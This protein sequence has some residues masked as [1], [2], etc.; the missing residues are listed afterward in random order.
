MDHVFEGSCPHCMH[1]LQIPAELVNFSCMY[2]GARLRQDE[3][4][5]P[6]VSSADCADAM[7][8]VKEHL[9]DA[10]T[11]FAGYEKKITKKEYASAFS[12]YERGVAKT[13]EALDRA[14]NA[15][16][17]QRSELIL[18]TVTAFID[19]TE[20]L[21]MAA[22]EKKQKQERAMFNSKMIIALF[23]VPAI[24]HLRLSVSEDYADLL[25]KQWLKRFPDNPFHPATYEDIVSGFRKGILCFITTAVCEAEGKP[26]NCAELTAFRA[27]R[28]GFLT[29][30]PDGKA[31]IDE[32]Y[33]IAPAIVNAINYCDQS[34]A[35]YTELREGFLSRCYQDLL[36]GRN[37][38]CKAEYTSMVQTLKHR[39]L[40]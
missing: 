24:R 14:C 22:S 23:L 4:I 17:A 37:E 7:D 6:E 10:L 40:Q 2:C 32:Y 31:L 19:G 16:P 35:V 36:A 26:D 27:F 13:Y 3:L 38:E 5:L 33:D 29:S 21:A 18:Q 9:M 1:E 28:D 11:E 34:A 39:Y 8:Y 25:H 30:C 12:K 20:S 15:C